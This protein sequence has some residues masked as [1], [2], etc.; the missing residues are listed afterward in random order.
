[1]STVS[2]GRR[3]G[4]ADVLQGVLFRRLAPGRDRRGRAGGLRIRR[5]SEGVLEAR[6]AVVVLDLAACFGLRMMQLA[7][8]VITLTA[9]LTSL[10]LESIASGVA[11]VSGRWK[12]PIPMPAWLGAGDEEGGADI[13]GSA[14]PRV[15]LGAE[16]SIGGVELFPAE[17]GTFP[18]SLTPIGAA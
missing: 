16:V 18:G 12:M 9:G 3:L 15:C 8:M 11:A 4:G 2:R 10:S 1:M 7:P 14:T 17:E 6:E 13:P 5:G